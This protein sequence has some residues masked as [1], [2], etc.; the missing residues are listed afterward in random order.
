MLFLVVMDG[1]EWG[2]YE[3]SVLVT[4]EKEGFFEGCNVVLEEVVLTE[5]GYCRVR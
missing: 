1:E 2:V 3:R 5:R 4:L